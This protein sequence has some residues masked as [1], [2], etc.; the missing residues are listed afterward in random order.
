MKKILIWYLIILGNYY[1]RC[2][3]STTIVLKTDKQRT[4][5]F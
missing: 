5:T 1:F 2:D 3:N 4:L